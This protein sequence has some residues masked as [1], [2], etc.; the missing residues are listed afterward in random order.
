MTSLVNVPA[1]SVGNEKSEE[2]TDR[3]KVL[4]ARPSPRQIGRAAPA[5]AAEDEGRRPS[6]PAG[7]NGSISSNSQDADR[8]HQRPASVLKQQQGSS[9]AKEEGHALGLANKDNAKEWLDKGQKWL[10]GAGKKLAAAAKEAQSTLQTKLEDMEVFKASQGA[11]R[12][13]IIFASSCA[14]PGRVSDS[15]C[16]SASPYHHLLPGAHIPGISKANSSIV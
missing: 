15:Q 6:L 2:A 14:V 7:S 12:A 13:L 10:M 1:C 5:Q 16:S 11:H 3:R 4:Q 9:A 8:R